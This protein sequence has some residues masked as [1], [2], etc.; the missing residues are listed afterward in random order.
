MPTASRSVGTIFSIN[1]LRHSSSLAARMSCLRRST[2]QTRE[3]FAKNARGGA[4]LGPKRPS[5][6]PR[7]QPCP[8]QPNPAPHLSMSQHHTP[9]PEAHCWG[10]PSVP[11]HSSTDASPAPP[12]DLNCQREPSVA[13]RADLNC[14]LTAPEQSGGTNRAQTGS[15]PPCND[16]HVSAGVPWSRDASVGCHSKKASHITASPQVSRP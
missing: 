9:V 5:P 1:L 15:P 7:A 2:G 12:L 16:G 4:C 6:A 11:L 13:A 14:V 8:A 3:G 10:Q